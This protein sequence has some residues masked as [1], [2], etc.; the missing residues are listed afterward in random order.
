[1]NIFICGSGRHLED[2]PE[3]FKNFGIASKNIGKWVHSC[4]YILVAGSTSP[5]ADHYIIAGIIEEISVKKRHKVAKLEL[6]SAK[7]D[8]N[9]EKNN[10]DTLM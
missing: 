1:M 8:V 10:K 3:E 5:N 2:T 9:N 4:H 6:F 7:N